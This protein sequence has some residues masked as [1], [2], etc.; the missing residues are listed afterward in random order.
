MYCVRSKTVL[1]FIHCQV[2]LPYHTDD[3]SWMGHCIRSIKHYSRRI[4]FSKEDNTPQSKHRVPDV[5]P[6]GVI[7]AVVTVCCKNG[8]SG[9]HNQTG[10]TGSVHNKEVWYVAAVTKGYVAGTELRG[11]LVSVCW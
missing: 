7:S 11:V 8:M 2:L 9:P 4:P 5:L 6:N 3:P 1:L 10:T